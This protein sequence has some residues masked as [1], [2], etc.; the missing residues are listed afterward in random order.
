MRGLEPP[1]G[2]PDTDLNRAR[3][4]IPPH[5]RAAGKR[6]Y[7]TGMRPG[8]S[9]GS[10]SFAGAAMGSSERARTDRFASLDIRSSRAAIVQG[11]RTPP[12]HGGNPGSN[13]GSGIAEQRPMV[14]TQTRVSGFGVRLVGRLGRPKVWSIPRFQSRGG[15]R[16]AGATVD[17]RPYADS[18]DLVMSTIF[19]WWR[20]ATRQPRWRWERRPPRLIARVRVAT[21]IW[22]LVLGA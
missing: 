10:E 20:E 7:R 17:G 18:A 15:K 1:P 4:P 13:P 12:S 8:R 19:M 16:R 14:E 5:P 11:T 22:L 3:L 21:G 6:R 2:F 9:V